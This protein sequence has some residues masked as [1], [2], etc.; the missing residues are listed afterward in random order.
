MKFSAESQDFDKQLKKCVTKE[1]IIWFF[2]PKI[3]YDKNFTGKFNDSNFNLSSNTY[4]SSLKAIRIKRIYKRKS[5]NLYS[6]EYD[7]ELSKATKIFYFLGIFSFV[8]VMNFMIYK[9]RQTFE[10]FPNCIF[11]FFNVFILFVFSL[12]KRNIKKNFEKEFELKNIV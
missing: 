3:F 1:P 2:T 6:I 11:L 4:F 10:I 9:Q 7:V 8:F 5:E 12:S